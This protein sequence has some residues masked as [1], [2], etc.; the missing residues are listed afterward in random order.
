[1]RKSRIYWSALVTA[2][3]VFLLSSPNLFAQ[4]ATALFTSKC[5]ACHGKDGMAKTPMGAKLKVQD[6]SSPEV[7]KLSNAELTKIVSEGKEKMPAYKTKLSKEQ[8]DG[9]VAYVRNFAKK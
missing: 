2:A 8:I 4:D 3:L 9:L 5:A 6:L 7:Q 1:M